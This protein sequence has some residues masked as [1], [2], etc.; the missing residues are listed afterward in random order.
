[1][2]SSE[3]PWERPPVD[4]P[5]T[6]SSED[7]LGRATVAQEFAQSIRDIDTSLGLVVGILGPWGHGK[8][9]F[10]NLMREQFTEAP[11][12]TVID[13][14]PWMFSGSNQLVNFFFSE[15]AAELRI[16]NKSRF[17]QAADWLAQYAA[18]LKPVSQF[19]PFPGA[20]AIGEASA[21]AL[22]GIAETT[23]AERSTNQLRQNIT[24]ALTALDEPIVVIIDDIDRL[25]TNEIREIFKLVRLTASFPNII[26]LLAFDRE[27]VEQA[28]T[29]DGIPGRAYLEK[30]VQLSFDVP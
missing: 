14:N 15:I 1:M 4:A 9:S 13:F 3:Y 25:T 6:S 11:V 10:V 24:Q 12:I 20:A 18:I 7:N 16:R 28:L 5:I 26:Y 29:E 23:T 19:I 21:A 22:S 30:I 17:G 27:R 2:N 8:S